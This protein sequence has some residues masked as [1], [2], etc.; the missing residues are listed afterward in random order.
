MTWGLTDWIGLTDSEQYQ[1]GYFTASRV[2]ATV[3]REALFAAAT[4]GTA[5][6]ACQ[7]NKLAR[8][9]APLLLGKEGGDAATG[10][11]QAAIGAHQIT[12]DAG[13][14]G[15]GLLNLTLGSASAVL[16]AAPFSKLNI[17][18][19]PAGTLVATEEGLHGPLAEVLFGGTDEIGDRCQRDDRL[20]LDEG[21]GPD[22][23]VA[24]LRTG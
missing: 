1:G 23:A 5:Q 24:E 14:T 12:L 19:F 9:A 4:A 13:E 2:F 11:A 21:T 22:E 16:S 15:T 8:G 10:L 18:C 7:G 6:A 17:K 3:A 20:R